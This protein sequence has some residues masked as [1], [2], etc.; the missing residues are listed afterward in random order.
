LTDGDDFVN[1]N[2]CCHLP[3]IYPFCKKSEVKKDFRVKDCNLY[4][5]RDPK[6][7]CYIG[8]VAPFIGEI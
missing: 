3:D 4:G 1:G 2:F 5:K 8:E 6:V 7:V